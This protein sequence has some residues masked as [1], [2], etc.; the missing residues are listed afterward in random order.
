[1]KHSY[2]VSACPKI[3]GKPATATRP[4]PDGFHP[5]RSPE[6]RGGSIPRRELLARPVGQLENAPMDAVALRSMPVGIAYAI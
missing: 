6:K 4:A 1:M 2:Q 3:D 5:T